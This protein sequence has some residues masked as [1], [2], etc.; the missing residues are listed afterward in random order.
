MIPVSYI[1]ILC[2]L[3][4]NLQLIGT[5]CFDTTF[6]FSRTFILEDDILIKY[7]FV[8][9]KQQITQQCKCYIS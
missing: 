5:I 7:F 6:H 3:E 1:S 2:T 4:K 8:F 9:D